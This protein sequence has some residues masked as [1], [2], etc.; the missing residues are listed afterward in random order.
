MIDAPLSTV[1]MAGSY[2]SGDVN[3]Q[4]ITVFH[5]LVLKYACSSA[6]LARSSENPGPQWMFSPTCS[7]QCA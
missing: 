2:R 4:K 5:V 1:G 3:I 7:V 6:L